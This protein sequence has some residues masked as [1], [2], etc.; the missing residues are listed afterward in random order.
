[1]APGRW[2]H[3]IHYHPLVLRAVPEVCRRAL[4]VGCGDGILARELRE[5]VAEVV[6]IDLDAKSIDR[7]RQ[8][9]GEHIDFRQGDVLTHPFA[10]ESFDLVAAVAS[11]HHMDASAGLRRMEWLLRPGGVLVVVGLARSASLAD[12]AFDAAGVVASA[13]YRLRR[14]HWEHG[15]PTL[16]P[17]PTTYAEMRRIAQA[18]LPGVGYRRHLLFRYS[19]TWT[20]PK[21]SA[22]GFAEG[23][24]AKSEP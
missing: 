8:Q 24:L 10:P 9:G 18:V 14:T 16:W 20:K 2:N 4:D 21:A 6:A 7:A 23:V 1:M 12:H 17:P 22:G 5:R 11:L 3:N 19:L 13:A 15:A